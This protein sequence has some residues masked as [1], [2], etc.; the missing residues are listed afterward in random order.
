MLSANINLAMLWLHCSVQALAQSGCN[1]HYPK[2]HC[3]TLAMQIFSSIS[4]TYFH[5]QV[6]FCSARTFTEPLSVQSYT[7]AELILQQPVLK[8]SVL[9]SLILLN[10]VIPPT[11]SL[12]PEN[13]GMAITCPE[14]Q[15][16][17]KPCS[18]LYFLFVSL[19]KTTG[20]PNSGKKKTNKNNLFPATRSI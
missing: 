1:C 9:S 6:C 4:A 5:Q 17:R 2:R 19:G 13:P 8:G 20:K 14:G 12:T 10:P 15:I 11:M 7:T 16:R 3:L 18:T